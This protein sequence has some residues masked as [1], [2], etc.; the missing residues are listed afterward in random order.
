MFSSEEVDRWQHQDFHIT[1]FQLRITLQWRGWRVF[2]LT[3]CSQWQCWQH[4]AKGFPPVPASLPSPLP[5]YTH[6]PHRIQDISENTFFLNC[7]RFLA[8][9]TQDVYGSRNVFPIKYLPLQQNVRW[10]DLIMAHRQVWRLDCPGSMATGLLSRISQLWIDS[11]YTISNTKYTLP[12]TK[13][14]PKNTI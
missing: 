2:G 6:I 11:K 8:F 5:L 10:K 14:T 13:H 7:W 1:A 3:K 12:N 4:F 9:P